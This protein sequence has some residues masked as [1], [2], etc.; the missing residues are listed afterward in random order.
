LINSDSYNFK[1]IH[2]SDEMLVTVP[3]SRTMDLEHDRRLPYRRRKNEEKN[4]IHWGQRKLLMS[5]IEFLTMYGHLS[6]T[7][8]YVGAADGRH[9]VLLSMMF[10]KHKFV[11]YDPSEFHKD[12]VNLSKQS[13]VEIH[14]E[15]FLDEHVELYAD[16]RVLFVSDIRMVPESFKANKSLGA[17]ADESTNQELEENVRHDMEL[18]KNWLLKL[19][20]AAAMMKFRLPYLPGTTEYLRGEIY[21][22]CWA[23]ATSTETRL[24]ISPELCANP[25][26]VTYDH[27]VYEA[28]M[29]RF[30]LCTRNQKHN[31]PIVVEQGTPHN[32]DMFAELYILAGYL[33]STGVDMQDMPLAINSMQETITKFF[34]KSIFEK[35]LELKK[36]MGLDLPDRSGYDRGRGGRGGRGRGNSR[37]R[38]DRGRGDRG[39]GNSRG[40]G[41]NKQYK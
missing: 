41:Q 24:V 18:Q 21:Y 15:L 17:E 6:E 26:F 33:S 38:G 39:R 40:R 7:V 9:L 32:Y 13:A 31:L 8:L 22:Q 12:L 34:Q 1:M 35:K 36:K 3:F 29:F 14:H 37:G 30:N 25:E 11:L 5:E 19:R 23:P 10:P 2:E 27:T 20:P 28:I 4:N 16:Q